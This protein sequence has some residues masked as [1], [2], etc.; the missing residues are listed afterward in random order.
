MAC[1][2]VVC[3]SGGGVQGGYV[4]GETAFLTT[5]CGTT[6]QPADRIIAPAAI[7]PPFMRP[8]E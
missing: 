4:T 1:G 3:A 6:V 2:E 8:S 5:A 7:Q